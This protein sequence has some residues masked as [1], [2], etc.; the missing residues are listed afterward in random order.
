V[1]RRRVLGGGNETRRRGKLYAATKLL[2]M[3]ERGGNV[4]LPRHLWGIAV[5][6][7]CGPALQPYSQSQRE[8]IAP[9]LADVADFLRQRMDHEPPEAP[10]G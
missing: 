10:L 3:V 9:V 7:I 1:P 6:L 4:I 2:M 8:V 5:T